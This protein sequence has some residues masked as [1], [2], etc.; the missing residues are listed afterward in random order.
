MIGSLFD[1]GNRRA[2]ACRVACLALAA[3]AGSCTR[4][5]PATPPSVILDIADGS[6]LRGQE[7]LAA[8]SLL[9]GTNP[10]RIQFTTPD[11]TRGAVTA[12]PPGNRG[13]CPGALCL[14]PQ[15]VLALNDEILSSEELER[16]IRNYS[17]AAKLADARAY[18]IVDCDRT[19]PGTDL[20]RV[21][22][23]LSRAD[24]GVMLA[25]Y[26]WIFRPGPP[27][28][29]KTLH[30]SFHQLSDPVIVR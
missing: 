9:T 8:A 23:L 24:I 14:A 30:R 10:V 22:S 16:K 21:L 20:V 29:Q 4:P 3:G 17:D 18:L 28:P 27:P 11:G 19:T 13:G 5:E 2:S 12:I 25:D 15:Q 7:I 1:S 26:G 6:G